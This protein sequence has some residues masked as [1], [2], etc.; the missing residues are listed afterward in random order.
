MKKSYKPPELPKTKPSTPPQVELKLFVHLNSSESIKD[1]AGEETK[2]V[3]ESTTPKMGIAE[4]FRTAFETMKAKQNSLKVPN[5]PQSKKQ[6][7]EGTPRI[8][9]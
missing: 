9:I 4:N 1:I 5:P 3:V 7:T 2:Q 8:E 6:V